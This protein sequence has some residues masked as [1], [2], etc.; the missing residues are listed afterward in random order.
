[1]FNELRI[2][3]GV[4]GGT[5]DPE[6]PWPSVKDL[7]EFGKSEEVGDLAPII[8]RYGYEQRAIHHEGSCVYYPKADRTM[9][10]HEDILVSAIACWRAK[11]AM[12]VNK[13][14]AA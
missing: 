9:K 5:K 10:A 12:K 11:F 1:M 4:R 2:R 3:N 13:Q 6:L 14:R 8:T 7:I